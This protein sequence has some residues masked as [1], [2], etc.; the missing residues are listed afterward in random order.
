[1]ITCRLL[2]PSAILPLPLAVGDAATAQSTSKK[3]NI[4]DIMAEELDIRNV[5]ADAAGGTLIS[6]A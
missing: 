3:L 5:N 1:M 4:V 2:L 6:H